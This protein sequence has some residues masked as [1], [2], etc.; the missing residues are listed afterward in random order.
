MPARDMEVQVEAAGAVLWRA[1][2]SADLQVA[3]VHRPRYDDWSLPKGKL[4]AGEHPLLGAL[5]E[6]DEETGHRAV[7][8]R[9][10][11]E[12]RYDTAAGF[13]R[14]RYWAA[15]ATT[16]RFRPG[17]EVD[18]LR[19]LGPAEATRLLDADRDRGV[20]EEFLTDTRP[21]TATAVV[22]HAS[23][24]DRKAWQG[25]D[26]LRPLDRRGR[27]Q[28]EQLVAVLSAYGVEVTCTAD[29]VR[30][31]DTLLPYARAA[32]IEVRTEPAVT[33]A[34]FAAD[35]GPAVDALVALAR[36]PRP[37]VVSAQREVIPALV[38]RTCG[39][40]GRPTAAVEIGQVPRASL[41]VLHVTPAGELAAREWL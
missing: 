34:A 23:A 5:R 2:G 37:A 8:G 15:R 21:T 19:W 22:R 27:R 24:G 28:A 38:A 7:P 35:P 40:L 39:R 16:G 4:D 17:R 18:Q 29:L 1:N 9:P 32:G 25:D 10:L 36:D 26:R 13:K 33:S 6:V 31:H 41:V 20:L 3:V 12:V 11:G 14:V 30:C